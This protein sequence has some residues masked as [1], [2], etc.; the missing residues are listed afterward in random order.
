MIPNEYVPLIALLV[1]AVIMGSIAL[2]NVN[3][4]NKAYDERRRAEEERIRKS[5]EDLIREVW[6][7]AGKPTKPTAAPESRSRSAE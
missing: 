7:P 3:G 5:E 2:W 6:G 4:L 1:W